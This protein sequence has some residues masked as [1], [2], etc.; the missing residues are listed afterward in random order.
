MNRP[1]ITTRRPLPLDAAGLTLVELLVALILTTAISTLIVNFAIDKLQQ[2]TLQTLQFDL[3]T[4]AETGLNRVAN[5][6]RLATSADENNRWDDNYA[7]AAPTDTLSWTSDSDTLVLAV[8]AQDISRNI[9][10][11]DAHD[12]VSAKNNVVY[13]LQNG[14]LYRRVLAAPNSNNAAKTTCPSASATSSCPADAAVLEN[15]SSF[16]VH[17]YGSDGSTVVPTSAHSV[18]LDVTLLKHQYGRDIRADYKTRM[19]FRNG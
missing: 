14:T 4:N 5:D 13:Y 18:Q 6:V 7:P 19:V 1:H 15:V 3:L 2:S 8:A 17:Y 12:Y 16:T 9:I 11:N 10:F